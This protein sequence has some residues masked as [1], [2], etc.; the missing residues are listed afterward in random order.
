[1]LRRK[2]VYICDRCGFVALEWTWIADRGSRKGP[3]P[4]WTKLG[5]KDLCPMCSVFTKNSSNRLVLEKM[6]SNE[7]DR[8]NQK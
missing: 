3:P 4:D 1:M 6:K 5:K 7:T 2:R 8:D